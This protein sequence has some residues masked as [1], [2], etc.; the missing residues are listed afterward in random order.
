MFLIDPAPLSPA[1]FDSPGV[2]NARADGAPPAASEVAPDA[3]ASA[4]PDAEDDLGRDDVAASDA[5]DGS[6]A[7]PDGDGLALVP[8]ALRPAI[9]RRGFTRLTDVQ[10]AVLSALTESEPT[11]PAARQEA[12]VAG[13]GGGHPRDLRISS[14]TG[15]GKTVAIGFALVPDVL[16]RVATA[17]PTALVIVPTRELAEQVRKE[18]AWLYAD[19]RDVRIEC[20]TGG[21][22]V[23]QE[24]RRLQR[25]PRVV[26][27][28]PGRLLDHVRA[29]ALACDGVRTVVLDE[30]DQ[31]LDLGFRDDLDAILQALPA[32]R[33]THMVSATFPPEVQRLADAFQKAPQTLQGTRLGVANADIEHRVCRVHLRDRYAALVNLLL[34]QAGERTLV[35]VRTRQDTATLAAQLAEDGFAAM[36][37]SGELAQT[38]RTRTLHAFRSGIVSVLVATDVAARGL[39]VPDVNVVVHF[40]LPMDDGVY[41][42]RSGRTGRAGRKG[43]SI[44]LVPPSGARRLQYMLRAAKVEAQWCEAPGP[45]E[46]HGALTERTRAR[47]ATLLAD[48]APPAAD[49]LSLAQELLRGREPAAVVARLLSGT[50]AQPTCTPKEIR[51]PLP[52]YEAGDARGTRPAHGRGSPRGPH[53][54]ERPRFDDAPRFGGARPD[55][56]TSY[57]GF[58]INWGMHRGATA[59]RLLAHVCRRGGIAGHQIGVIDVQSDISTFEVDA[60][61]AERFA[62]RARELDP[63]EPHLVIVHDGMRRAPRRGPDRRARR[64]FA[65]N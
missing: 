11:S 65:A 15:S 14:Q 26:V 12:G 3:G 1:P 6:D 25:R 33:R 36:A 49:D 40:D 59:K 52:A 9:A 16:G 20:V 34:M 53:F 55:R 62:E 45:R 46:V 35:F 28:T 39:D 7:S 5:S 18:L 54:P 56:A 13:S 17:S 51:A 30:A 63:R 47:L 57:V 48:E 37:L 50:N 38:Q 19:H 22:S 58:S 2:A 4:A 43:R 31:M 23:V 44:V 29:G 41:T 61:V 21:T 42:H 8:A 10:T 32:E 60:R 27:A 64:G 24:Q